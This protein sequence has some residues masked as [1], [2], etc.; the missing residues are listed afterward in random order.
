VQGTLAVLVDWAFLTEALAVYAAL[1][2][3]GALA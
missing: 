2:V 1:A 3:Q